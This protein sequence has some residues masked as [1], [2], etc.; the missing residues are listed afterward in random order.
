MRTLRLCL[1][2]LVVLL[3]SFF[4]GQGVATGDLHVTVKDPQGSLVTSAT[5][6]VRDEAKGI[7]RSEAADIPRRTQVSDATLVAVVLQTA[8]VFGRQFEPPQQIKRVLDRQVV[9][10]AGQARAPVDLI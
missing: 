10:A 9:L 5:V 2:S 1:V 7:E 3:P 8:M 6:T 4:Y